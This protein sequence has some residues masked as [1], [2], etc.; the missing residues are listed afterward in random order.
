ML[1][2]LEFW[3]K[4][5]HFLVKKGADKTEISRSPLPVAGNVGGCWAMLGLVAG[6]GRGRLGPPPRR[7]P[8]PE[9]A[10]RADLGDG[11]DRAA[12]RG[13]DGA[14]RRSGEGG[15]AGQDGHGAGRH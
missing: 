12:L 8:V 10:L 7:R 1:Q 5:K 9:A 3:I 15:G 2:D 14:R 6:G 4:I 13:G 11:D